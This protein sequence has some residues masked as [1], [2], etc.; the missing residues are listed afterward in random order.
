MR[1]LE[2]GAPHKG[3]HL[4][5]PEARAWPWVCC[6]LAV[7]ALKAPQVAFA[8][9]QSGGSPGKLSEITTRGSQALAG[10]TVP[11]ETQGCRSLWEVPG[12]KRKTHL[13]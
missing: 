8:C 2:A 10:D 13:V 11:H 4:E 5:G 7:R 3:R 12:Q 1:T 9:N 6:G